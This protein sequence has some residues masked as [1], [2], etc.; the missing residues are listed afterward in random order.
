MEVFAIARCPCH[1][2]G[3]IMICVGSIVI[4]VTNN[5]S[6]PTCRG[7]ERADGTQSSV[8]T[9][10]LRC[11]GRHCT[12]ARTARSVGLS[13]GSIFPDST[14]CKLRFFMNLN[15]VNDRPLEC[16]ATENGMTRVRSCSSS[17]SSS[18]ACRDTRG[19][20]DFSTWRQDQRSKSTRIGV[21]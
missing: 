19:Q 4:Y 11:V 7:R 9:S 2:C 8:H 14:S 3:I 6:L 17:S 13:V 21:C 12:D 1:R 15:S 10:R 16:M 5:A 18:I 20:S